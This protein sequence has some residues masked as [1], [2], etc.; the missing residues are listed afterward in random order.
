MKVE[1]LVERFQKKDVKAFQEL[2]TMY[3]ENIY[4]VIYSVVRDEGLSEELCQDVFLKVWNN[5]ATY[6]V[7]KGRF[8][9]WILKIARNAAIDKVRSKSYQNLKQNL[10]TNFFVSNLTTDGEN[11]E[12]FELN[13]LNS[14][15][16]NLKTKCIEI[17]ELLYFRGYSQKDI[18]EELDIPL[19]TVKT[20]NRNCISQLRRNMKL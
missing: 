6:N 2:Y 13:R 11:D 14:L 20:R 4:G 19:G 18:A 1:K 10:S 17:I 15:V 3:S 7:S 5:A 8:F 9:T 16:K 12:G